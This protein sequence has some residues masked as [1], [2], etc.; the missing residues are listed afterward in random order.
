[1]ICLFCKNQDTEVIETRISENGTVVRR[2]RHCPKC[3]KRFT[4]YERVEDLPILVIK[5]EGKRERFDPE[6][7]RRGIIR[8]TGKTTVT[9]QQIENIVTQVESEIKQG[10]ATEIESK[11]IGNLVAKHLKKIDKVAYIRFASVFRRFVDVEEFEKE[12]KKLI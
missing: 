7:L 12:V 11:A 5:R 10:D 9:A 3:Q 2:R 6:K 1:M 4:T 8:A